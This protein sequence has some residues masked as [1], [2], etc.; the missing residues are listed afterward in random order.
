GADL[1][2]RFSDGGGRGADTFRPAFERMLDAVAYYPA[3]VIA[4]IHGPAIGA[5]MQLAIACDLRV[6]GPDARLAIPGGRLG[7]LLSATNIA[8]LAVLV[9]QGAARDFLLTGR[10]VDAEEA[11]VLGLVQRVADDP[12]A[13][14]RDL[15]QE[16]ATLAPL[17]VQGH[18]RALDLVAAAASLGAGARAEIDALEAAAFGSRDLEEGMAAFAEK[19]PPRFEGA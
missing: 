11:V 12:V 2:S 8:R 5:G 14:A 19:R 17:T 9:G 3:P 7:I 13:A 18:K 16:I 15:A 1:G 10:S 6:A 4:A